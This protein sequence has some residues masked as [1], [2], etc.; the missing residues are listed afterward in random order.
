MLLKSQV[1][2][3]EN[4]S[5]IPTTLFTKLKLKALNK[6]VLTSGIIKVIIAI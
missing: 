2:T 5:I 4:S 1:L 6:K 3:L